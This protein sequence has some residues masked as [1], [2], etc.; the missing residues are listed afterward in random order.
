MLRIRVG[1]Q[2]LGGL[3]VRVRGQDRKLGR[4]TE[5]RVGHQHAM[6]CVPRCPPQSEPNFDADHPHSRADALVHHLEGEP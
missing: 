4:C 5:V 2:R 1:A 6:V 3:K